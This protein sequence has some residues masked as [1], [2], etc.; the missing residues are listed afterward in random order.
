MKVIVLKEE[1]DNNLKQK[2]LAVIK[3]TNPMHDEIHT[4]IR[5]LLDIKL[6]E[7]VFSEDNFEDL[8]PDFTQAMANKALKSK[9]IKVYSSYSIKNG[10][11]VTTSKM[12]AKD[13][14]GD[15]KIYSKILSVYD[16]A[17]IDESEGQVAM[18]K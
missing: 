2:Q 7:E 3:A 5:T 15:G 16:I 13:Y 1:Q 14:A 10:V 12:N 9:K 8:Y 6:P 18:I 17:W 11:F 4:G